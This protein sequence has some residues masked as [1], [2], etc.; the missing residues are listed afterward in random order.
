MPLDGIWIDMNEPSS[1]DTNSKQR[2]GGDDRPVALV[3]L[4]CNLTNNL[5]KPPYQTINVYQYKDSVSNFN[6]FLKI[7]TCFVTVIK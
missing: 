7:V 2:V 4:Q 6:L 5:E 3:P 1:F